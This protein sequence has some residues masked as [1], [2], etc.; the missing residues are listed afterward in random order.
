VN[1]R[2]PSKDELLA[3]AYVDGELDSEQREAFEQ[4]LP[5]E[6]QLLREVAEH[7]SLA[8]LARQLTPPEPM[9][10]EW[11]RLDGENLHGKGIPLGLLLSAIGALGLIF[12]GAVGILLSGHEPMLKC[13]FILLLGGLSGVFL[14][15]FRARIQ[16][17]HLDPYT[18]VQR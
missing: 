6:P 17:Q 3:M 14:L 11:R 18:K 16:T 2:Q 4:R 13:F 9:D 5:E 10:H 12:W 1:D 15:V 8:V 7:N